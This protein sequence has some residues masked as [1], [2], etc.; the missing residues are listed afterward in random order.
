MGTPNVQILKDD[1]QSAVI[2]VTGNTSDT[3]VVVNAKALR[4]ANTSQ[5]CLV[6]ISAIQYSSGGSIFLN[7]D[8]STPKPIYNI[9]ANQ[10][11]RID[12]YI[13]NNADTPDGN[14]SFAGTGSYSFILTLNKEQGYANAFLLYD[15][16]GQNIP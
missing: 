3:G 16:A 6:T 11:G 1:G 15:Y 14:I 12:A 8:G 13:Q 4:F 7:W 5:T 9:G 10:S 2:K